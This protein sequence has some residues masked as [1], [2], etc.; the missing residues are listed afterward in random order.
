MSGS[1]D[2]CG[3]ILEPKR[4]SALALACAALALAGASGIPTHDEL[5]N[6]AIGWTGLGRSAF[7]SVKPD[8]AVAV[9]RH[10]G[11]E[12]A[13]GL[14]RNVD[15]RGEV[16]NEAAAREF[17]Y[18]SVRSQVDLDCSARRDR[19]V[20]IDLYSE[21]NLGGRSQTR[22]PPGGWAHPSPD[23]YLSDV[24]DAV[25]APATASLRLAAADEPARPAAAP[26]SAAVSPPGPRAAPL[27]P[28]PPAAVRVADR[29]P[30]P[31]T[32]PTTTPEAIPTAPVA[33]FAEAQ[34]PVAAPVR[35]ADNSPSRPPRPL[36]QLATAR[37]APSKPASPPLLALSLGPAVPA[38]GGAVVAQIAASESATGAAQALGGLKG[39]LAGGL[40]ARVTPATVNGRQVY[41]AV[42]EGFSARADALAFCSSRQKLGADCWVR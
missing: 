39:R 15:L 41:R 27:R 18:R 34:P 9:V 11:P 10:D 33:R 32:P 13:S 38:G 28:P 4:S 17:G 5:I 42:V 35:A 22:H 23:A 31:A 29:A 1:Q 2:S 21:H 14:V 30:V 26:V 19:V 16:T 8:M 24:M 40:T 6:R 7:V 20:R 25:C 36:V 12:R 37:T 3:A